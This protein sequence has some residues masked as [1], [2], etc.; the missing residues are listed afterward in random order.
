[1]PIVTG[2]ESIWWDRQWAIPILEGRREAQ[3]RLA[4][5]VE[6]VTEVPFV[7]N[8]PLSFQIAEW[9]RRMWRTY[10]ESVYR[11]REWSAASSKALMTAN[12]SAC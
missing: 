2:D 11:V 1:L 9:E 4:M 8:N 10:L 12:S 6:L 7:V 3:R 5:K